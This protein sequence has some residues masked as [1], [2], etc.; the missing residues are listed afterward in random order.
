MMSMPIQTILRYKRKRQRQKEKRRQRKGQ[1]RRERKT[2]RERERKRQTELE[3]REV[4]KKSGPDSLDIKE[5]QELQ[6]SDGSFVFI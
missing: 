1:C 2:N 6:L 3:D 5:L 4:E